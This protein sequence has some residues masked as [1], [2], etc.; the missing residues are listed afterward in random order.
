MNSLYAYTGNNRLIRKLQRGL[1]LYY[2]W[3]NLPAELNKRS[4]AETRLRN[5]AA[6]DGL[7]P[8]KCL[9]LAQM[10]GNKD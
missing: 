10:L 1:C 9:E 5:A 3:R 8:D 6:K 4:T 2:L 7:T